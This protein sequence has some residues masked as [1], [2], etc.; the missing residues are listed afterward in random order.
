VAGL[1]L[2]AVT[3]FTIRKTKHHF[4]YG[5]PRPKAIRGFE[6]VYGPP[7]HGAETT[8]PIPINVYGPRKGARA[9]T[10]STIV[11]ELPRAPGTLPWSS[12]PADSIEVQTTYTNVGN[13]VVG[14]PWIGYLKKQGLYIT[15][16][17]PKGA[18]TALEIARSLQP[19]GK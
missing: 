16:A 6:L 4:Y 11:Y 1:E 2:R 9:T 3:P 18:R 7:S 15:I 17:T 10:R 12:V 14:T 8:L 5:A 13:H 19:G